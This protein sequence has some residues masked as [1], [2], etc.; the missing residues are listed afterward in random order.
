MRS[1]CFKTFA[2][3]LFLVASASA[4]KFDASGNATLHGDYFVREVL[5]TGTTDG[6]VTA[7]GSAIGVVTFDGQGNYT[8]KGQG[9]TL[10]GGNITTNSALSLSG[11]YQAAANGFLVMQSLADPTDYDFGGVSGVG[12]GAFVASATEHGNVT[13]LIGIPAGTNVSNGALNGNYTAGAIDFPGASIA[14]VREASFSLAANGAGNIGSVAV[15]GV[16]ASLGGTTLNQTVSGV[17]YSLSG[18]GSG[19]IDFGAAQSS[20]LVSGSKTFYISADGNIVLGGSPGGFDVLVGIR[21]LTG[22]ASN[23]TENG[24]YYMGALEEQIDTTGQSANS[25]DAFYGSVNA[26]GAGTSLFHNR[27]QALTYAVYDYTFDSEY[28]VQGDG[29]AAP[30]D[31]PYQFTL[32][33][34]GKAFISLGTAAGTFPLYSLTL[35]LAA[36]TYAGT[37]VYLNPLG[38]VSSANF[39][40]ATNPIAPNELISL[41]GTGM[42]AATAQAQSLPLPTTLGNVQVTINGIPAPLD[43]VS[44]TMITA[45]VPSSI[46]PLNSV[47]YATVQVTN[48]GTPSNPVTVYTSNTAPGVFAQPVAIGPAA[49]QHADYSVISSGSPAAVG[50]TIIVYAGGLG[51]VTP[52]VV[53]DGG[54]ALSSPPYNTVDA[55]V[56]VDFSNVPATAINFAGLTPTTAGL[57]QLNVPIPSGTGSDVFVDVSTPDGVT[58]EATLSVAASTSSA[59]GKASVSSLTMNRKRPAP[60]RS[61]AK[62]AGLSAR[63]KLYR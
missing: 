2:A 60:R 10:A 4:Q 55:T 11:T 25:I 29:T 7:A 13:L 49:A 46:S 57:Y 18:E 56:A 26:N 12:P 24:I 38:V 1:N 54:P 61:N 39:A 63:T 37:G 23:A 51:A 21:S 17:T 22:T 42:A 62:K 58:S 33:D 19:T 16:G 45:L 50:E 30:A 6:A 31:V 34:N 44:P 9:T 59:I 48:N 41:F 36:Q 35:G 3:A 47:Y 40:P 32:G 52:A 53:P 14:A 8:F 28:T 27:I 20:Q 15:T 5:T 43:Y